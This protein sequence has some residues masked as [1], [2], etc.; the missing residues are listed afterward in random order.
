MDECFAR[1]PRAGW[2]VGEAATPG[3]WLVT[4]TNGE[5]V[6]PAAAPTRAGAWRLAVGQAT[7]VGM[8]GR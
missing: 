3:G 4:G 1:L 2:C 8:V 7:T 6:I 5:H